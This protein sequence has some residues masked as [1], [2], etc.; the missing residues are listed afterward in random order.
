MGIYP[1]I[2]IVGQ[3]N[4]GKSTLFNK[5]TKTRS[6]IV[7]N[8]SGITKDRQYGDFFLDSIHC[9]LVDTAGWLKVKNNNDS[10]AT[11]SKQMQ[12]QLDMALNEADLIILVFDGNNA[13]SYVDYDII[14]KTRSQSKP[15]IC[16]VNKS[17][18]LSLDKNIEFYSLGEPF[19]NVSAINGKGLLKLRNAIKDKLISHNLVFN[20]KLDNQDKGTLQDSIN[21]VDLLDNKLYEVLE[22]GVLS[23]NIDKEATV[24]NLA[25]VG[26]PN[27]GK[28][29][30]VN[31]ILGYNRM[32][33]SDI[34]GTTI[35]SVHTSFTRIKKNKENK[36]STNKVMKNDFVEENCVVA[37]EQKYTQQEYIL[38]DTAGIRRKSNI[39]ETI[40]K[41]SISKA[42]ETVDLADVVIHVI[43]ARDG[44]V[45]QDITLIGKSVT[46]GKAI[47]IAVN[48]WDALNEYHRRIFK[49]EI[50]RR[51]NFID[52]CDIKYISA[53]KKINIESVFN[54]VDK[55]FE[56]S[57]RRY[58]TSKLMGFLSEIVEAKE[59]DYINGKKPKFKFISQTAIQPPT[60]TIHGN[61]KIEGLAYMYK[62]YLA[63]SFRKLCN[64]HGSAIRLEF[65]WHDNPFDKKNGG[66]LRK[67]SSIETL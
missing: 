53:L 57:H 60:L 51:L 65:C 23:K 2:A 34:A 28:S 9:K 3:P 55:A 66:K 39:K 14:K 31:C 32:I 50:S 62:R 41:F 7:F 6:A 44:I 4:V 17:D 12:E 56:A 46:K 48:Q 61:T 5:L 19:I 25:I 49:K 40:E 1:V 59:P 38:V 33:V 22:E 67:Y 47:V 42:F 63:N 15:F 64:W 30:L 10:S 52:F 11:I 35:D 13:L 45:D 54:S 20:D 36:K 43:N 27:V 58:N 18:G 24:I 29:T 16:I 37:N 26:R 21:P 8:K